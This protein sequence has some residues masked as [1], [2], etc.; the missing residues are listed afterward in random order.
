MTDT[1]GALSWE[2]VEAEEEAAA[3]AAVAPGLSAWVAAGAGVQADTISTSATNRLITD[4]TR[5]LL[6]MQSS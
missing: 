6:I 3:G 2:E 4:I 1:K 5:L